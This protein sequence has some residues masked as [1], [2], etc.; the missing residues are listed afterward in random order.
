MQRH[1]RDATG[2][3][4]HVQTI[5]RGNNGYR[6]LRIAGAPRVRLPDFPIGHPDFLSAY[7]A[8]LQTATNQVGAAA[9]T[10]GAIVEGSMRS[11]A[12]AG[13]SELYAHCAAPRRGYPRSRC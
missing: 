8:A 2:T 7:V 4:K 3:L 12:H 11:D 13:H 6:S 10:V 5:R 1:M 9:G